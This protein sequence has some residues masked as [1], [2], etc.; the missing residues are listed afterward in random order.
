MNKQPIS[1]KLAKLLSSKLKFYK[2]A[3]KIISKSKNFINR[4]GVGC[5]DDQQTGVAYI[6]SK[7]HRDSV[8]CLLPNGYPI[9]S[10]MYGLITEERNAPMLKVLRGYLKIQES[11]VFEF[12]QLIQ[13]IQDVHD[14]AFPF[15]RFPTKENF[16]MKKFNEGMEILLEEYMPKLKKTAEKLASTT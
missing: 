16:D 4:Q 6:N 12:H 3:V 8:A 14:Y 13:A 5:I 7:G 15:N 2:T 1:A 10:S 9:K 11:E